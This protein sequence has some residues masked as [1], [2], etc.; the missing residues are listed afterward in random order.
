VLKVKVD[1][2]LR[3]ATDIGALSV[4]EVVMIRETAYEV[5]E[6]SDKRGHIIAGLAI[7]RGDRSA[8]AP[9]RDLGVSMSRIIDLAA[10]AARQSSRSEIAL[11]E[12][13]ADNVCRRTTRPKMIKREL[14]KCLAPQLTASQLRRREQKAKRLAGL[15]LSRALNRGQKPGDR[16]AL[17]WE[18]PEA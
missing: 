2:R 18:D 9:M 15:A 16:G 17:G 10:L 13:E 8:P 14:E 11:P 3:V 12:L 6:V 4:G 7:F 5:R 1:G